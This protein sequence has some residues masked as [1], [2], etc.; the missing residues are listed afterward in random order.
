MPA[1]TMTASITTFF[2]GFLLCASI[3]IAVGPQNLFILRQGL[4]GKHVFATALFSTL[5]DLVLIALAVGGLSAFISTNNTFKMGI[6]VVGALFLA[7]YGGCA[8]LRAF[9]KGS[10]APDLSSHKTTAG[11][12]ATIVAALGFAFLNPAAYLDTLM[13]IGSTSLSFSASERLI[14]G[15]GAVMASA[16]WFFILSYGA[17]HLAALF[18]S[19]I[20][21]HVLDVVS[22]FVMLGIATTLFYALIRT[23]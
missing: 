4:R 14:F 9:R 19:P 8:L 18:Q 11:I 6:T 2:H 3:I 21:W 16:T 13:I 23:L 12:G 7:Y 1:M 22:G 10:T 15:G 20:A 17:R 5:A